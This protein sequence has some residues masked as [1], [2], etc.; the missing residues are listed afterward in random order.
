MVVNNWIGANLIWITLGIAMV[1]VIYFVFTIIQAIRKKR[2]FVS[3]LNIILLILGLMFLIFLTY[4]A[5]EIEGGDW[6]QI[7]LMI[8]LVAVTAA[9]ASSTEKQ[10][11]ASMKMAQEMT[12]PY[13]MLRL[14]QEFTQ[15]DSNDGG[16][17][18]PKEFGVEIC[19][20]GSGPAVNI[21][22]AMWRSSDVYPAKTRSYLGPNEDWNVSI[23]TSSVD[24]YNDIWLPQLKQK[25][26]YD[27]PGTVAI[28]YQDIHDQKWVSYLCLQQ[29]DEQNYVIDGKQNIFKV[30]NND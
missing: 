29:F 16:N 20:A 26:K 25:V 12:R 17:K 15:L 5:S 27:F 9:Y 2:R 24:I 4:R 30:D 3:Q 18:L 6:G 28:E 7:I 14:A 8:G 21:T 19:N 13:L 23:S 10:A 1:V 11:D 22:V